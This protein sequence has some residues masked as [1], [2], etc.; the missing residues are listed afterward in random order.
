MK[1]IIVLILCSGTLAITNGQIGKSD[2]MIGGT[3]RLN[4]SDNN[5]EIAF[6]PT[7]GYFVIDDLALG[8]NVNMGYSKNGSEKTTVF[9]FGPFARFYF[10]GQHV[11]PILHTTL[12]FDTRKTKIGNVSTNNNGINYFLGGGAALFISQQVSIDALAGYYHS[13]LKGFDGSGGFVFSIGFQVYLFKKQVEDLQ[14][15]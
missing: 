5:T 3:F 11:R 10:N 13:K 15:K 4:T 6:N 14:G 2:W 8:G 1:K 12:N 9:G 7:A